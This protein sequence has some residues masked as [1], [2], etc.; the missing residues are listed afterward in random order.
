MV[1]LQDYDAL[2]RRL[3]NEYSLADLLYVP[4]LG[5]WVKQ[6]RVSLSEP[7]QPMKLVSEDG[8]RLVMVVQSEVPESALD[9]VIR[10]LDMRWTIKNVAANIPAK[11]D[12]VE[13]RLAYCFLKEYARNK[14]DLAG[15]EMLEDEWA[16]SQ[17]DRLGFFRT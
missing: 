14:S 16:V 9:N 17:M 11:L 7:A 12:S 13:K 10:G 2:L 15:D 1:F 6:K 5:S 8:R 3:G 4:H